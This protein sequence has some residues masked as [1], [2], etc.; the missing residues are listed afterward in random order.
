MSASFVKARGSARA[1]TLVELLVVIGIIAVLIGILLPAL[2]KARE[3]SKRTSC[4]ANL[5][6]LG[7]AMLLYCNNAKDRLPNCNPPKT[8]N[9]LGSQNAVLTAFA[10][11]YVRQAGAF[12]CPSDNDP[13]QERDETADYDLPNSARVSYEFY[14]VWWAPEFGPRWARLKRAPLAWDLDGGSAKR[15]P[16][17]NHD[18]KGGNVV[19]ADGHADW[20]DQRL[21]DGSNWANPGKKYYPAP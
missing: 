3:S 5:R 13:V 4:L 11:K 14:S 10:A 9:N 15:T 6:T 1:F 8:Y 21:W 16:Y 7:Q 18:T 17:Q 2:N 20:Q 12:H 19:Y